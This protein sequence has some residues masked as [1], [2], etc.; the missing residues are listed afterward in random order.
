MFLV[1][2]KRQNSENWICNKICKNH[3]YNYIH[4][5]LTYMVSKSTT[6]RTVS[7][8][9]R[10]LCAHLLER[11]S[12]V[13]IIF[14][15]FRDFLIYLANYFWPILNSPNLIFH[16][17]FRKSNVNKTVSS[18]TLTFHKMLLYLLQC[19]HCT[20]VLSRT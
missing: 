2:T 19:Y 15:G 7:A 12:T 8:N 4:I 13:T 17:F 14:L 20:C 5:K 3:S 1:F 10:Q 18:L 9:P 11:F 6:S 16:Q